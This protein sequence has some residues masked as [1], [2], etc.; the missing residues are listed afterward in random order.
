MLG[1]KLASSLPTQPTQPGSR[2]PLTPLSHFAHPVLGTLASGLWWGGWALWVTPPGPVR[3]TYPAMLRGQSPSGAI[4]APR[5]CGV[6]WPHSLQVVPLAVLATFPWDQTAC[7]GGSGGDRGQILAS[8]SHSFYLLS[9]G[10]STLDSF[11]ECPLGVEASKAESPQLHRPLHSSW[12]NP[13][14]LRNICDPPERA[15]LPLA[16]GQLPQHS[17]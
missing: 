16:R 4:G 15:D 11:P 12:K 10:Y 1:L 7:S 5:G 2:L 17:A 8:S 14:L 3:G 6:C 13:G 9:L